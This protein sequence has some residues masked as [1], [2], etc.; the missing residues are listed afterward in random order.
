[1]NYAEAARI[2]STTKDPDAG[3]PLENNTRLFKRGEDYA[4]R[5]HGTDVVIFHPDDSVTLNSGGWRTVTTKDRFN[6]YANGAAYTGRHGGGT[7]G[8]RVYSDRGTW[9]LYRAGQEV[10]IYADGVTIF[11]DGHVEGAGKPD[12]S[13]ADRAMRRRAG[14][15]AQDYVSALYAG[16]IGVPGG[17]DCWHCLMRDIKTGKPA[18]TGDASH[19][20]SHMDEAYY[21]PSLVWNALEMFGG[22]IAARETVR[23]LQAGETCSWAGIMRDQLTRTIRRYVIRQCGRVA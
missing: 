2:F 14:K 7:N 19:M 6:K 5:L 1:M 11:P 15:Y 18:F 12:A 13:A 20:E 23:A 3:K 10:A 9:K 17:G 22:S 8:V 16:E 21:V 4:V